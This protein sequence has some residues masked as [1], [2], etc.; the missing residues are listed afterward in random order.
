MYF[1][2]GLQ[3]KNEQTYRIRRRI[4]FSQSV[5]GVITA[6][7]TCEMIDS[8]REE[9][10]IEAGLLL[11]EAQELAKFRMKEQGVEQ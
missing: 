5:K 3:M 11:K 4:N 6:E 2:G 8:T 10:L 7:I 9:L 1:D